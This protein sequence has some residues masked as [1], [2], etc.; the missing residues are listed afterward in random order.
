MKTKGLSNI[1]MKK[2]FFLILLFGLPAHS[3]EALF[4]ELQMKNYEEMVDLVKKRVL[5]AEK[6]SSQDIDEA[7][8]TLQE[9]L[10]LIFSRPNSDNMVSQ[11]IPIVR[12][13][14]KNID[15]YDS[16]LTSITDDTLAVAK[17]PKANVGPQATAYV[18]LENILSE[19]KPDLASNETA[20]KIAA[21][22]RDAKLQMPDKVK[23]ELKRR[24]MVSISS[25][26][27]D[28]AKQLLSKASQKKQ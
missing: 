2:L 17:D 1:V 15:A 18:R 7:K 19:I 11:L 13:P 3:G 23:S 28:L 4:T 6:M 20:Q 10:H 22:I 16:T 8:N 25:T 27:S 24:S 12:T 21:S 5:K 9:A 14:L 26:P